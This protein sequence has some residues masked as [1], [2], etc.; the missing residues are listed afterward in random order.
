MAKSRVNVGLGDASP[1]NVVGGSVH[2]HA[3]CAHAHLWENSAHLQRNHQVTILLEVP[4]L[5]N[6]RTL[7]QIV[8]IGL[9]QETIC[10]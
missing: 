4:S 7:V 8:Q 9:G 10:T 6:L 3:H 1:C 5:E 2:H